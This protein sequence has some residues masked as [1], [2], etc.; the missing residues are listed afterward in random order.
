MKKRSFSII[1]AVLFSVLTF[2]SL[3]L[4]YMLVWGVLSSLKSA[5]DFTIKTLKFPQFGW[6]F[7]NYAKAFEAIKI[8]LTLTGGGY[9][10]IYLMDMFGYS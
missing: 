4:L 2:Y 6:R 10:D 5:G 9:Q 7:E 1:N 8:R 3:I